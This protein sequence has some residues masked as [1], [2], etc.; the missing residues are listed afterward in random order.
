MLRLITILVLLPSSVAVFPG[1]S[2]R[3]QPPRVTM[4]AGSLEGAFFG[5]ASRE[6]MFLGIPYAEPPTGPL[7]W[8]PPQPVKPWAGIRSAH[9]FAASCPQDPGRVEYYKE[10]TAEFTKTLPYYAGFH[11]NEDCLYLNI[12]TTNFGG[13]KKA[14]VMVWIHGGGNVEGT[15]ELPAMGP[16]MARSGIVFVSINYRLGILGFLSHPVLTA[17]SPHH[18]SGNYALLDQ[19]AAL[20]WVKGNI[21]RFGGAPENVTVFGESSGAVDICYLMASPLAHGIFRQ[22]IIQSNGCSDFLIPDL[23]RSRNIA[24]MQ[25]SGEGAGVRFARK[26]GI[27]NAVDVLTKLRTKNADEILRASDTAGVLEAVDGWVLPEQPAIVFSK[28]R[29][30]RIP[31]VIG[32]NADERSM[33]ADD[34]SSPTSVEQYRTWL[35]KE[36]GAEWETVEKLYPATNDNEAKRAF[37]AV[38]TDHEFGSSTYIMAHAMSRIGQ[39]VY[40]YHF[41]YPSKGRNARLGSYHG[42]EL[43]FLAGMARR[44]A[45][46]E[47]GLDDE[48]LSRTMSAYWSRFAAKG[49]P[50]QRGLPEWPKYASATQ[51]CLE[52]GR[53][54][55]SR[56]IP[57]VDRYKVFQDLLKSRLAAYAASGN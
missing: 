32:S 10:A 1:H 29:Q 13:S 36:F 52:L 7:R 20:E 33:F 39:T 56:S 35:K 26:L 45:W 47:F 37:L 25:E 18:S 28:G 38:V 40:F 48:I 30:T 17:E 15:G 22:A 53:V 44:S 54:V 3:P 16:A 9:S 41:T 50:N 31:V 19:I 49:N 8:K 43:S 24:G 6:V 21:E 51:E 57:Y 14:A 42:L 4:A 34:P 5:Q 23:R 12:W 46:G 55:K 2:Q 27:E 11:A